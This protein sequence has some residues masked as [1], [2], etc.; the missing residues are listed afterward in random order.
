METL[1]QFFQWEKATRDTIDVK[2][3]YIDIADDLIAGVL[4]S[5]IVYWFLPGK[6]GKTK[7]RVKKENH[8]WLVKGRKDW[9]SECRIRARQY[10]TAIG[11]LIQK[12][13]VETRVY[14][15]NG[16]PKTHVR[17]LWNRFLFLLQKELE[18]LYFSPEASVDQKSIHREK[19]YREGGTD[20][21]DAR[22]FYDCGIYESVNTDLQ[23]GELKIAETVISLTESTTESTEKRKKEE[24]EYLPTSSYSIFQQ[25]LIEQCLRRKIPRAEILEILKELGEAPYTIYALLSTFEKVMKKYERGEISCFS[26]YFVSVLLREQ[27]RFEYVQTRRERQKEEISERPAPLLYNWLEENHVS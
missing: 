27:S 2:K 18:K 10:D 20:T 25:E 21:D 11:K 3:I 9:F 4:L 16:E 22:F 19:A 26:R 7:L 5:Q 13:I 12:G 14:K 15:F 17:I 6:D 1:Q 24:E 23:P 8:Y